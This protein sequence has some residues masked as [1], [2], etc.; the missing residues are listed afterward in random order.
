M[1]GALQ[2][3]I[4][5]RCSQRLWSWE[6]AWSDLMKFARIDSRSKQHANFSFAGVWSLASL[7]DLCVCVPQKTI[8]EPWNSTVCFHKSYTSNENKNKAQWTWIFHSG[9]HVFQVRGHRNLT[10]SESHTA[11]IKTD[12]VQSSKAAPSHPHTAF[13]AALWLVKRILACSWLSKMYSPAMSPRHAMVDAHVCRIFFYWLH[14][15]EEPC[16]SLLHC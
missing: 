10:I 12:K 2:Q 14:A 15:N 8:S 11:T 6:R 4:G 13:A 3:V 9:K 1:R 16:L 7:F 5:S